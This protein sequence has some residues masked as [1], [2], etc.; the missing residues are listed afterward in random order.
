MTEMTEP[1]G[2]VY[3]RKPFSCVAKVAVGER[4]PLD[5]SGVD[6]SLGGVCLLLPEFVDFGQFCV[7]KFEVLIGGS[8]KQFSAVAKSVY[9][10]RA[11]EGFRVGFQFFRLDESNTALLN[12]VLSQ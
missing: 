10:A 6:I 3:P 12:Q 7:V 5:G 9:C 11:A 1:E 2:R 4:P 8:A